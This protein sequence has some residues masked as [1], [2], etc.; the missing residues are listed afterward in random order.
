MLTF[1]M[2]TVNEEGAGR[3]A[4][5]LLEDDSGS[6]DDRMRQG[7]TSRRTGLVTLTPL[8]LLA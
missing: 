6:L 4:R 3:S 5:P 2:V 8:G 7:V 1:W